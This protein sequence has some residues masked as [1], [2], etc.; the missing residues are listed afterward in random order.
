[1]KSNNIGKNGL[2]DLIHLI[3]LEKV[4]CLDLSFN[5]IQDEAVVDEVLVKMNNLQVL[6]LNGNPVCNKIKNYRRSV[7]SRLKNLKYLDELP[8]SENERKLV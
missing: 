6:Y 8:I 2:N 3:E 1:M 7:I 5:K 4:S